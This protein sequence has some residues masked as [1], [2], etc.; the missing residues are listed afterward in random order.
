VRFRR[1]DTAGKPLASERSIIGPPLRAQAASLAALGG[2]YAITYRALAGGSVASPEVRLA[3]VSK[4]GNVQRDAGGHLL[5]FRIGDATLAQGR[6]AVSVSV[7]GEIMVA[8]IDGDVSTGQNV[9]KVVRRRLDC[10]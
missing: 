8:W 3:F 7:E 4:E 9:L 2:G 6:T 5:S 1:L 10:R